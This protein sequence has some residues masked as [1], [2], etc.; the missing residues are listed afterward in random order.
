MTAKTGI[1]LNI[2]KTPNELDES[3]TLQG[4]CECLPSGIERVYPVPQRYIRKCSLKEC[5]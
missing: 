2:S 5:K 3:R 1:F 4:S